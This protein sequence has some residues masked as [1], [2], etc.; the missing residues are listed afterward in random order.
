MYLKEDIRFGIRTLLK[1]PGFTVVA[2]ITLAMGIGVNVTMFSIT[3]G[4]IFKGVPYDKEDRVIHILERD[5]LHNNQFSLVSYPDFRD[6]REQAKSFE[7]IG[8]WS[9]SQ[10]SIADA[11]NLPDSYRAVQISSNAF[12]AMRTKPL[13]GRDFAADDEKPGAAPV[14]IL[15]YGLWDRRYGKD[16]KIVGK[17][18]RVNDLVTTVIAV[19]PAGF[20]FPNENDLWTPLIP[21]ANAENRAARPLLVFGRMADGVSAKTAK[22]EMDG[23]ARNLEKAYPATNKG[24]TLSMRTTSEQLVGPEITSLFLS[25]MVAVGFVLLIACANVANLLLSRAVGRSR[26]IS[27]RVAIGAGKWRI[28]R[29][30]LLESVILSGIGGFIGWVIS[31]WGVRAFDVA[32][33]PLGRPTWMQFSTDYRV[34]LYI[35]AV[36]LGTGVLFGLAPALRLASLDVNSALKDGSRGSSSGTRGKYLSSVLVV[37]ELAMAIILL[38]GAGVMV[39]SFLNIYRAPLGVNTANVL[40][41]R[42][43]LPET[44]YPTPNDQISFVDRTKAR[45]QALPGVDSVSIATTLPTGGSTSLP[46]ELEGSEPLEGNNRPTIPTVIIDPDYFRV[47]DVRLSSGR[48]F[49]ERDRKTDLAVVIVNQ[50]AANKLWSGKDPLGKRIRFFNGTEAGDWATVVGL[51]PNILQND[52]SPRQVDPVIYI[53]FAQKTAAG[54]AIIARTRVPSGALA[55]PFRKELQAIDSAM[56]VFNLWT[57]SERLQRNY[58]LNEILS[59]LFVIFAGIAIVLA[60]VGLYAVI[61]NSV[62]QRTQEIGVRIAMGASARDI[63]RLV[64]SFAMRRVVIGLTVGLVGAFALTRVLQAFLVQ[65]SPSDPVT[66]IISSTVLILSSLAGCGIPMARATRVDPLIALRHD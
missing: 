31:I 30:L 17:D 22:A 35:I 26:E 36:S 50:Y 41:M 63:G 4:V 64:L 6:F 21:R 12:R 56:P 29:Q 13:I 20:G 48:T 52:I 62:T 14:A 8:A 7:S 45:L 33:V 23:I 38:A 3:N 61:S 43:V 58:G 44:K 59:E 60:S 57:M 65:V 46:Y 27:I 9:G 25:M 15:N 5:T 2:I 54:V 11:N 40:T 49:T 10:V 42:V 1:S 47:W 16:P 51:A 34:L 32:T 18:I 66:F 24:F 55:T 19:M 37:V 39:R 28:I 53:P